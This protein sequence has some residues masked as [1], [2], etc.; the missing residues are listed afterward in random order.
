VKIV[1]RDDASKV[2][3][4]AD[5]LTIRECVEIAVRSG[6]NLAY[7]KLEG[8]DLTGADLRYVD[9]TGANLAYAKLA[10]ANLTGA[11]LE[12]ANIPSIPNID[13]AILRAIDEGG[14]LNMGDWH[15][16]KTTHCRAGWAIHLAG[17]AG[18]ELEKKLG[19]SAAGALIYA[20]SR[21]NEPVPDF[22]ATDEEALADIRAHAAKQ[23]GAT[24]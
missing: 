18:R 19:P 4:E 20:A 24:K 23:T 1:S 13:A 12:G 9:L 2:L 7:A 17:E 15:T 10:Y 14:R 21:P 22:Y 5:V 3:F 16:C 6:A 11:N 8:V